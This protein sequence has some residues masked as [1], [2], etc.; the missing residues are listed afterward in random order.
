MV[1]TSVS[2]C[3]TERPG[4]H[5]D[6]LWRRQ[7]WQQAEQPI[8]FSPSV[9]DQGV[10][11][12]LKMWTLTDANGRPF[13]PR[14]I[15]ESNCLLDRVLDGTTRAAIKDAGAVLGARASGANVDVDVDLLLN[16]AARHLDA[17]VGVKESS[18]AG[19]LGSILVN[20]QSQYG[21]RPG[22]ASEPGPFLQFAYRQRLYNGYT[23]TW[24]V[25]LAYVE[26]LGVR[27]FHMDAYL[28]QLRARDSKYAPPDSL[29]VKGCPAAIDY[30]WPHIDRP[31]SSQA[32]C[33][34]MQ[35]STSA[36]AARHGPSGSIA[37]TRG[38]MR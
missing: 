27:P 6:N 16:E 8:W 1:V 20:L 7:R 18:P 14:N 9:P 37:P 25:L 34:P 13:V 32:D 12:K 3:A 22:P 38:G 2:A 10:V 19:T 17:A 24:Y 28:R 23:V 11:P 26:H 29:R 35:L 5:C 4:E 30:N 31:L 21:I 33:R 36:C 15:E